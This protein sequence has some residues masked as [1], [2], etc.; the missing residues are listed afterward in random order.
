[1]QEASG[2]RVSAGNQTN[3]ANGKASANNIRRY[4][5]LLH[6]CLAIKFVPEREPFN[7]SN[8]NNFPNCSSSSLAD[9][10]NCNCSTYDT[11]RLQT[12]GNLGNNECGKSDNGRGGCGT[13]AA[14][15]LANNPCDDGCNRGNPARIS[16]NR[17][18]DNYGGNKGRK[19]DWKSNQQSNHPSH[20]KTRSNEEAND[21]GDHH[22]CQFYRHQAN[23]A[24]YPHDSSTQSHLHHQRSSSSSSL[25]KANND[26]NDSEISS[27]TGDQVSHQ[28]RP[29]IVNNKSNKVDPPSHNKRDYDVVEHGSS[30][31]ACSNNSRNC[32]HW[33]SGQLKHHQQQNNGLNSKSDYLKK[34]QQQNDPTHEYSPQAYNEHLSHPHQYIA[35]GA[36]MHKDDSGIC[37]RSNKNACRSKPGHFNE[38]GGT[39]SVSIL[40]KVDH[41]MQALFLYKVPIF[42]LN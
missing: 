18:N 39:N 1:M 5:V 9:C 38:G 10:S 29:S 21:R 13:T 34:Q 30:R 33:E 11:A 15:T 37:L 4:L 24:N 14:T 36:S 27:P 2:A 8:N 12:G 20:Q 3:G 25:L 19:H 40:N 7:K 6:D 23:Q 31:C 41:S 16:C 26:N 42:R 28:I 32:G 17:S 22:E 35:K